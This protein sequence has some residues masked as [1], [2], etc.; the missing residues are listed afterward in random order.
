MS[1]TVYPRVCG[2]ASVSRL[3]SSALPLVGL[4][5]RVRG[6]LG[7]R[8]LGLVE[9]AL[10]LSPRVRGSLA[11]YIDLGQR[12]RRR[13]YPRVCGA[14]S[15]I[16]DLPRTIVRLRSIPAC[17]GQP[18]PGP[19]TNDFTPVYPRVCGAA[20]RRESWTRTPRGL[21]PRV[22]GSQCLANPQ[23]R[24]IGSIPACAGQPPGGSPGQGHP[25]GLSPRVRGSQCLANPQHRRIG[26]IPACAGQPPTRLSPRTIGQVY[27]RV[28]GAAF[29]HLNDEL[30]ARGLSP[31]VRGS[32]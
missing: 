14:A 17:A 5:P 23:H 21:S 26:S 13:V 22:R 11:P 3:P 6:S 8:G 27:P 10:G 1:G 32:P 16:I 28:C 4:S 29:T 7:I 15:A 9:S 19:A 25:R 30:G 31:R 20:A 12:C 24:R 2:A 18:R